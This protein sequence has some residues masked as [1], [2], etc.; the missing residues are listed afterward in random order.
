MRFKLI[1]EVRE[2][3]A[4]GV[5][6]ELSVCA[7]GADFHG[8]T[9]SLAGLHV[10]GPALEPGDSLDL[11]Q[12][13]SHAEPAGEAF[14]AR[15]VLAKGDEHPDQVDDGRIFV[16]HDDAARAEHR[17][18]LLHL[19]KIDVECEAFESDDATER[20]ARLEELHLLAVWDAA[21]DLLDDLTHGHAHL[22]LV[23]AGIGNVAG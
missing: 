20:A 4:D 17:A 13:L 16:A 14:A 15:F 1:A 11:I 22:D 9:H 3:R 7:E 2:G 8:R 5:E 6:A 12:Q 10:S 23:D 18:G 21:A 19:V